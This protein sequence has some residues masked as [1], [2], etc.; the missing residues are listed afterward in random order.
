MRTL[1]TTLAWILVNAL[2]LAIIVGLEFDLN[3]FNWHLRWTLQ[4]G[5]CIAGL[6]VIA[7]MLYYLARATQDRWVLALSSLACLALV[8]IVLSAVGPEPTGGGWLGRSAPSPAWYRWGRVLV[9][10]MPIAF[11]TWAL[12]RVN[13]R[14]ERPDQ[15]SEPNRP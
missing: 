10:C 8:G 9:G 7:V 14:K 3:F 2:F 12:V 5:G 4:V 6:P 13:Q 11:W 15:S 1:F